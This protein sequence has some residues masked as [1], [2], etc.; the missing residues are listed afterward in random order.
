MSRPRALL[1]R[2]TGLFKSDVRER[3]F[4]E[5]LELH[6]DLLAREYERRGMSPH[7]ARLAARREFGNV[8]TTKETYREQRSIPMFE[9]AWHDLRY[10]ARQ[11][12]RSPA[13]TITAVL[14]LALGLGGTIAIYSLVHAVIVR[15]LPYEGA[16][17]LIAI[18]ET[19]ARGGDMAASWH[20]FLDWRAQARSF[21]HMAAIQPMGVTLTGRGPAERVPALNVSAS[22]LPMLGVQPIAGRGIAEHDDRSG[23]PYTIL[24]SEGL[25][26]R[27]FAKSAAVLGSSITLDGVPHTIIGVL[28]GSFRM[29]FEADVLRPIGPWERDMGDRSNHPGLFVL[30]RLRR[31][32]PM[33]QARAEMETIAAAL[34]SQYPESNNGSSVKLQLFQERTVGNLRATLLVL[35]GAVACVLLIACANVATLLMAR[36]SARSREMSVRVAL[37]AGYSRL[38]KQMLTESVLLASIAGLLGLALARAVTPA[39]TRM[40]PDNVQRIAA[41]QMDWGVLAVVAAAVMVT[42]VSFGLV[43]A[44]AALRGDLQRGLRQGSRAGS[45]G[46]RGFTVRNALVAAQ[47]ALTLVLLVSAGLLLRSL[48]TLMQVDPGFRAAH[49]V[50]MRLVIPTATYPEAEARTRFADA[51]LERVHAIPGVTS[52]SSAFCLPLRAGCWGTWLSIEGNPTPASTVLPIVDANSIHPAYLQTMGIPLLR[53]RDFNVRDT[54]GTPRVVMV[55]AALARQFFPDQDPIGKRIKLDRYDADEGVSPWQTIVGVVGDVRRF[56]LAE[57]PRPEVYQNTRQLGPTTVNLAVRTAVPNPGTITS[58]V[59]DAVAAVDPNIAVSDVRTID[60]DVSRS[61]ASR[62]F[63]LTILGLFSG[64]ALALA[65]IG[66]YGI[67]S[68]HVAERGPELGVRLALGALPRSLVALIMRSGLRLVLAGVAPGLA[69]AL[70]TTRLLQSHLYGIQPNDFATIAFVVGVLTVTALLACW[71]SARGASRVDPLSALRQE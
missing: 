30:G 15:G 68:Y 32:V 64:L 59:R 9:T 47:V 34:R 1:D 67:V 62:R 48:S 18:V 21:S 38:L 53:G 6:L 63:P 60:E 12:R 44:L 16:D 55:S 4:D 51:M 52:A 35:F 45:S 7:D 70:A 50:T 29:P 19:D 33:S 10:G 37:G 54:V 69:L 49:L 22:L 43:P 61:T 20:N 57:E 40:M 17:R 56:G 65:I 11:L 46:F 3:E 28:P 41:V 24:L 66:L 58:A 8:G 26:Q 39:L 36:A 25:W 71:L 27:R 2:L 14:T 5:E 31:D 13:F 42:S 23:A